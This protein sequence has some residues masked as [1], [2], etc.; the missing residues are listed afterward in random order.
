[1]AEDVPVP[2][3]VGRGDAPAPLHHGQ[4][5]AVGTGTRECS[6]CMAQQSC[7]TWVV[8][9]YPYALINITFS[10]QARAESLLGPALF[11]GFSFCLR[12]CTSFQAELESLWTLPLFPPRQNAWRCVWV[13]S[14]FH[15][16]SS[17]P[18]GFTVCSLLAFSTLLLLPACRTGAA[19]GIPAL[20]GDDDGVGDGQDGAMQGHLGMAFPRKH[21]FPSLSSA[22]LL[23]ALT[24]NNKYVYFK[25]ILLPELLPGR[26]PMAGKG[27]RGAGWDVETSVG[28]CWLC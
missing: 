9:F 27:K 15:S 14:S 20:A 2:G 24:F 21:S 19:L 6:H 13:F 26:V 11:K 10:K 1:M 17:H 18:L 12:L 8:L 28:C 7:Q 25:L 16:S 3:L 22:H 4:A 23:P 5:E